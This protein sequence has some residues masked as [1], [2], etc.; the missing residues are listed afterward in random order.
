MH[1]QSLLSLTP[2]WT[3]TLLCYAFLSCLQ[4]THWK[5]LQCRLCH[6]F[7]LGIG[8]I[9]FV[10][11][12]LQHFT[13][14]LTVK[15]LYSNSSFQFHFWQ[16]VYDLVLPSI[17]MRHD[18]LISDSLYVYTR[19]REP[20]SMSCYTHTDPQGMCFFFQ[21]CSYRASVFF[22]LSYIYWKK[23]GYWITERF[24]CSHIS[25]IVRLN[26]FPKIMVSKVSQ[27][28]AFNDANDINRGRIHNGP[29]INELLV[30]YE[31]NAYT[32]K[33]EI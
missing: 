14:L 5:F 25:S 1:V 31:S 33:S 17:S 7:P 11:L 26:F 16:F 29:M 3:L 28:S 10:V 9:V 24:F 8:G 27:L 2:L 12:L 4:M 13:K 21:P 19:K 6:P 32:T 20:S 22:L 18:I 30:T 23:W 15:M